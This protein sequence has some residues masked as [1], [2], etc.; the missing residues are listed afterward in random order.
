MNSITAALAGGVTVA[1]VSVA[2]FLGF[3]GNNA[4]TNIVIAPASGV[5]SFDAAPFCNDPVT[6][7]KKFPAPDASGATYQL[8]RVRDAK[9]E[10]VTVVLGA[11]KSVVLATHYFDTAI[12]Q[13]SEPAIVNA[14][15]RTCIEKKGK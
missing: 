9:A 11:D 15:S 13:D 5:E 2:G 8:T 3:G 4:P 14:D 12:G 7:V 6:V 10:T 1:A